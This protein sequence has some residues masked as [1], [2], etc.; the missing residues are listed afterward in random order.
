MPFGYKAVKEQ[1]DME[2]HEVPERKTKGAGRGTGDG[3]GFVPQVRSRGG[4]V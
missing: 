1:E 2:S 3:K 4:A